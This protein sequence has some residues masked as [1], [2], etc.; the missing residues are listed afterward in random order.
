MSDSDSLSDDGVDFSAIDSQAHASMTIEEA[1]KLNRQ[2]LTGKST[3]NQ[4]EEDER[5]PGR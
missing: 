4:E 2:K 5:E 1:N 3:A